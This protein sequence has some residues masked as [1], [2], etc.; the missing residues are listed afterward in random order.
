MTLPTPRS[1][2]PPSPCP[3]TPLLPLPGIPRTSGNQPVRRSESM[4]VRQVT[5][6]LP[7]LPVKMNSMREITSQDSVQMRSKLAASRPRSIH[8]L[9]GIHEGEFAD[10]CATLGSDKPARFSLLEELAANEEGKKK[11]FYF[12]LEA[13]EG[14]SGDRESHIPGT[15][16]DREKTMELAK[17]GIIYSTVERKRRNRI[18]SS[19]PGNYE[20]PPDILPVSNCNRPSLVRVDS[21]RRVVKEMCNPVKGEDS[22]HTYGKLKPTSHENSDHVYGRLGPS[23]IS[24]SRELLDD[25]YGYDQISRSAPLSPSD[26]RR[27]EAEVYSDN[28]YDQLDRKTGDILV[29][30][31]LQRTGSKRGEQP[32]Y[33]RVQRNDSFAPHSL[34]K[35]KTRD[36][37]YDHVE[38]KDNMFAPVS[39]DIAI[40]MDNIDNKGTTL[41]RQENVYDQLHVVKTTNPTKPKQRK[42]FGSKLLTRFQFGLAK[43]K[44]PP[45]RKNVTYADFWLDFS[46]KRR[47][48]DYLKATNSLP[49]TDVKLPGHDD[50]TRA[51][52][53][54]SE[55]DSSIV[56]V[57]ESELEMDIDGKEKPDGYESVFETTEDRDVHQENNSQAVNSVDSKEKADPNEEVNIHCQLQKRYSKIQE[58]MQNKFLLHNTL[59][60]PAKVSK[61]QEPKDEASYAELR[62]MEDATSDGPSYDQF[63]RTKVTKH[64]R[65]ASDTTTVIR[66]ENKDKT[67]YQKITSPT[68]KHSNGYDHLERTFGGSRQDLLDEEGSKDGY[69]HLIQNGDEMNT[70]LNKSVSLATEDGWVIVPEKDVKSVERKREEVRLGKRLPHQY[71]N[72]SMYE[73]IWPAG[74]PISEK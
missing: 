2:T 36:N 26:P 10:A 3:G 23:T 40:S 70:P 6:T 33:D 69:G 58:H 18:E 41:E 14:Q 35:S 47:V 65:S 57:E 67:G 12:T 32:V 5:D 8:G 66:R 13:E 54:S 43:N 56:I 19:K 44:N 22:D 59:S 1:A 50:G 17:Q 55:S 73:E 25:T 7:K 52:S 15:E 63:K 38:R 30:G 74:G 71:S 27:V 72:T 48:E 45:R 29:D 31:K 53:D 34:V 16:A 24:G 9:S 64:L 46:L 4:K 62:S 51:R 68:E 11:P 60:L 42:D 61:I 39:P 37:Q 28:V 21:R 49:R 20:N